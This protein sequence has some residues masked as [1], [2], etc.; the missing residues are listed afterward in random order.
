MN[1]KSD[2]ELI[3]ELILDGAI[4]VAGIEADTGNFL[5]AFTPKIREVMP[6]LFKEHSENVN[7]WVMRLWEKG[8]L[9]IDLFSD[10]PIIT[11]TKKALNK[12]DIKTLSNQEKWSLFE[13]IRL[14]ERKV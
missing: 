13:I 2:N 7:S 1:E 10:D 11:I 12:E 8:F 4:E 9:D 5:Y 3:N 14:L 6:S